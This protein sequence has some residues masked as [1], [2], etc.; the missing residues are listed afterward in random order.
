MLWL[1]LFVCFSVA[2]ASSFDSTLFKSVGS[3]SSY[4]TTAYITYDVDFKK[5][6]KTIQDSLDVIESYQKVLNLSDTMLTYKKQIL[7]TLLNVNEILGRQIQ[8]RDNIQF[9]PPVLHQQ[10]RNQLQPTDQLG[11]SSS[12]QLTTPTPHIR[13]RRSI[14]LLNGFVAISQLAGSLFNWITHLTA[15]GDLTNVKYQVKDNAGKIKVLYTKLSELLT[16][17]NTLVRTT[18][19]FKHSADETAATVKVLEVATQSYASIRIIYLALLELQQNRLPVD[20]VPHSEL[21]TSYNKLTTM[22]ANNGLVPIFSSSDDLYHIKI[23]AVYQKSTG[24]KI[25]IPVFASDTLAK[26]DIF[27]LIPTPIK[28]SNSTVLHID[29]Q[30]EYIAVSKSDETEGKIFT[31]QDFSECTQYQKYFYC[32]NHNF[33][34]KD[35]KQYCIYNMYTKNSDQILDTCKVSFFTE[36]HKALQISG[37]DFIV[38]TKNPDTLSMVCET[39]NSSTTFETPFEFSVHFSLNSTCRSASTSGYSFRYQASLHQNSQIVCDPIPLDDMIIRPYISDLPLLI[40]DSLPSLGPMKLSELKSNTF[41]LYMRILK[42]WIIRYSYVFII[43]LLLYILCHVICTA[44]VCYKKRRVSEPSYDDQLQRA[45]TL[46][47]RFRP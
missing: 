11:S 23:N 24:L 43:V 12:G 25:F 21:D 39:N 9:V 46:A 17:Y 14:G 32:P 42:S 2:Y 3:T 7:R 8:L 36:S 47:S 28:A 18:N 40:T 22:L 37:N 5:F 13:G 45:W 19:G 1:Q 10:S 38:Y 31:E 30:Y 34:V 20:L 29:S 33:L 15:A 41:V 35:L 16:N 4:T 6:F 44:K 27:R 26:L